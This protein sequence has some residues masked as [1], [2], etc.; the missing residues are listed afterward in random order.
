MS[1]LGRVQAG[2]RESKRYSP[3]PLFEPR[4]AERFRLRVDYTPQDDDFLCRYLATYHPNGSWRSRKTYN[5]LVSTITKCT[6]AAL[7]VRVG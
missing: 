1:G 2:Q 3:A 7:I 6:L 4:V 5:S